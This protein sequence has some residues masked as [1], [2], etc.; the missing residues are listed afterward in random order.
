MR[1]VLMAEAERM[2]LGYSD[3]P[4]KSRI[5]KMMPRKVNMDGRR[6]AA[7]VLYTVLLPTILLIVG[8]V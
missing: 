3:S 5:F 7:L 2:L 4:L 6:G 8:L 1:L